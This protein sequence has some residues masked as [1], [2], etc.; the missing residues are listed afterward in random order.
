MAIV[1]VPRPHLIA[2]RIM[3]LLAWARW[4]AYN[5]A[6]ISCVSL[7][8]RPNADSVLSNGHASAAVRYSLIGMMLV[9]SYEETMD[10]GNFVLRYESFLCYNHSEYR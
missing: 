4:H 6:E 7:V 9:N 5:F 3:H 2:K 1:S 8:P 10:Q